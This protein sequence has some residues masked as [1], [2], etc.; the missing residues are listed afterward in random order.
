MK[1]WLPLVFILISQGS[2]G[3]ECKRYEENSRA[4]SIGS[5]N[6]SWQKSSPQSRKR[7]E[8]WAGGILA[9]GYS[10]SVDQIIVKIY[11]GSESTIH[12]FSWIA[13]LD[14]REVPYGPFAL[15]GGGLRPGSTTSNTFSIN[16]A[17][18]GASQGRIR[19]FTNV[20]RCVENYTA[21][22]LNARERQRQ[23]DEEEDFIYNNCL[24]DK[25]QGTS[26]DR[27]LQ[28]AARSVCREIS[29]DPGFMD[30]FRYGRN[31]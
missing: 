16:P 2:L 10:N 12:S 3:A 7:A 8:G 17:H 9:D 13:I 22:E 28:R 4:V 30:R 26:G 20:T 31:R 21:S 25:L 23:A 1:Y 24:T 11:N 5:D 19:A 29:E 18:T 15:R 6:F 27:L 14:D